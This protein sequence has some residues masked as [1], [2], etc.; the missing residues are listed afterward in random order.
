[1]AIAT[2]LN[3]IGWSW[4]LS[5]EDGPVPQGFLALLG[6]ALLQIVCYV[7]AY[8]STRRRNLRVL[9][10]A[11][12]LTDSL[13]LTDSPALKSQ[14][15]GSPDPWLG[16][17][18][19]MFL[20]GLGH[21]YGRRWALGLVFLLLWGVAVALPF[22]QPFTDLMGLGVRAIAVA[23]LYGSLRYP[24]TGLAGLQTFQVVLL[25]VGLVLLSL[26]PGLVVDSRYIPSISMAPTL[27]PGDRI[28]VNKF[29][30]ALPDPQRGDIVV[31][32][33]TPELQRQ[34]FKDD[35]IKRVIGLP[36][37]MVA[38]SDGQVTVNG[39]VLLEPYVEE[40]PNYRWGP[41]VVPEGEYF[42]LGDA[43][44]SSYDSHHWGFLPQD[45]IVGKATKR[46]WPWNRAGLIE[47]DGSLNSGE[48]V[49]RLLRRDADK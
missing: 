31:F 1:M 24:G 7:D 17:F 12:A 38:V 20:P 9:T 4:L 26:L 44:N 27:E 48:P 41:Q 32:A 25:T 46:F 47:A 15:R 40:I 21:F 42:V 10:H 3:L 13:A 43:R 23:H 11:Q 2:G 18:L 8:F 36:G 39:Q 14:I 16:V 35:F 34:N 30:Y 37:E 19:T 33:P 49:S 28:I 45:D 29:A 22:A 6:V 5:P